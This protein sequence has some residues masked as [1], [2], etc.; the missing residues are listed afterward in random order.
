[1]SAC[2]FAVTLSGSAFV[3][4]LLGSAP[5]CGFTNPLSS[6]TD[7]RLLLVR[8]EAIRASDETE[9]AKHACF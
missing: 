3:V 1:M 6:T 7:I 8:K 9:E 5:L 4:T 2:A